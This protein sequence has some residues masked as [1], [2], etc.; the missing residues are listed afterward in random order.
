M[1]KPRLEG[2]MTKEQWAE[3]FHIRCR[4]KRGESVALAEHDLCTRA[5]KDDEE[6][7]RKMEADVFDAT[8]PF[9]SQA[10]WRR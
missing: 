2:R 9:G 1:T 7:Y 5:F 10:R 6:R 8:V 3:V 4:S